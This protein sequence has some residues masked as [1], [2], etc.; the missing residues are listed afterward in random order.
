MV[1]SFTS[2]LEPEMGDWVVGHRVDICSWCCPVVVF[3]LDAFHRQRVCQVRTLKT[4]GEADMTA[5]ASQWYVLVVFV[6]LCVADP[7]L[8]VI[9][10]AMR[11]LCHCVMWSVV[12]LTSHAS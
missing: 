7:I 6:L 12:T 3:V 4:T 8:A 9:V 10:T 1:F 2:C 11:V 5:S